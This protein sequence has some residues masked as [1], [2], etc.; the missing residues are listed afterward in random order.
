MTVADK[1]LVRDVILRDGTPLRLHP[2]SPESHQDI[3][4]FHDGLAE[5]SL[6]HRADG[7]P[8][9]G[10]AARPLS[11]E[12]LSILALENDTVAGH[13]CKVVVLRGPLGVDLHASTSLPAS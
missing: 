12:D 13:W 7:R 6:S 5:D 9:T 10:L 4:A 11:P 2:P 8:A 1:P 3:K